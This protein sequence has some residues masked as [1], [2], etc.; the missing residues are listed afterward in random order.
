MLSVG[1]Y[2][3]K[4]IKLP[5]SQAWFIDFVGEK[6]IMVVRGCMIFSDVLASITVFLFKKNYVW[7]FDVGKFIVGGPLYKLFT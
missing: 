5:L 3:F 4:D 2:R 1:E 6:R 7:C